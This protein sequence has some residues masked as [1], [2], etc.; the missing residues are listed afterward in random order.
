MIATRMLMLRMAVVLVALAARPASALDWRNPWAQ[1]QDAAT[2]GN[3]SDEYAWRLFVAL[4]WPAAAA[5]TADP[6]ARFGAERPTV[7]ESWRNAAEVYRAGGADP[8]AWESGSRA[9]AAAV[10]FETLALEELPPV[11]H[12]VAGAMVPLVDP[13]A[14]ARRLTEIRMNRLTFDYIRDHG[15]YSVEGQLHAVAGGRAVSFPFGAREVKAKWRPIGEHDRARYHT[16]EVTLADGTRRL[17]GLTALHIASKDLPSWFWATFEHLDNPRLP[18]NEGWQRPSRDRF[19]CRDAPPD[20]NRAPEAIGV[21]GTVWRYY[22]LRGTMTGFVDDAGAP[23][24]LANSELESGMQPTAS[25]I[26]CHSRASIGL[27]AGAPA[28]LPVFA[29]DADSGSDVRRR[30]GF[31]GLPQAAWFGSRAGGEASQPMFR[32]LDFVWSLS[33]AKS[34]TGRSSRPGSDPT[35]ATT[36]ASTK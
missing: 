27:I 28:R 9:S 21:E 1:P 2:A 8:G 20:C 17:Y 22:R 24:L 29:S 4:N 36:V 30:T 3:D 11:R 12:I 34:R 26:T 16:T 35:P 32:R 6:A 19:A 23:Q 25:C 5:G 10:R 31:T 14:A 7:W 13:I 15:L 33:L 18:D